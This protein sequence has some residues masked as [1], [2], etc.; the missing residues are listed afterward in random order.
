M[1]EKVCKKTLAVSYLIRDNEL[2]HA[3]AHRSNMK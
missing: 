3:H 2:G 1:A